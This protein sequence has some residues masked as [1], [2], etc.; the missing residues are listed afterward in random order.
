M[1]DRLAASASGA[2]SQQQETSN[3]KLDAHQVS[4]IPATGEGAHSPAEGAPKQGTLIGEVMASSSSKTATSSS[5][6]KELAVV[7]MDED[8]ALAAEMADLGIVLSRPGTAEK[9]ASYATELP[10]FAKESSRKLAMQIAERR[11]QLSDAK[12]SHA[13]VAERVRVMGAHLNNVFVELSHTR[14]LSQLKQQE[15]ETVQRRRRLSETA[16][17]NW[18]RVVEL[19]GCDT[20]KVQAR[21]VSVTKEALIAEERIKGLQ[22]ETKC[23]AEELEE[24]TA[25]W[26][27]KEEDIE[28]IAAFAKKDRSR[29]RGLQLDL[30]RATEEAE[31]ER[32]RL[33][34]V[35][36]E[37]QAAQLE[38]ENSSERLQSVIKTR[39]EA[40]ERWNEYEEELL[41][42]DRQVYEAVQHIERAR[43]DVGR[44]MSL[45][46]ELKAE[47]DKVQKKQREVEQLGA[48]FG[49]QLQR[50]QKKVAPTEEKLRRATNEYTLE[51]TELEALQAQVKKETLMVQQKEEDAIAIG[52]AAK[53]DELRVVEAEQHCEELRNASGDLE[54]QRAEAERI[55]CEQAERLVEL[56]AVAATLKEL[57]IQQKQRSFQLKK[58][59]E[60][61]L[62]ESRDAVSLHRALKQ[63]AEELDTRNVNQKRILYGIELKAQELEA[64]IARK[65]GQQ[66]Q[67]DREIMEVKI[68]ELTEELEIVTKQRDVVKKD[69]T[70]TAEY[71]NKVTAARID[72]EH[73]RAQ[74]NEQI[75][76][77][78]LEIESTRAEIDETSKRTRALRVRVE[79]RRLD[80]RRLSEKLA[81][82]AEKALTLDAQKR[83]MEVEMQ[84]KH[85]EALGRN[86]SETQ[87]LRAQ[88]QLRHEALMQ[89]R[90][91]EKALNVLQTR[92]ETLAARLRPSDEEEGEVRSQAYFIVK[93]AQQREE[94][95]QE[96]DALNAEIKRKES[97]LRAMD[98]TLGVLVNRNTKFRNA[99]KAAAF[100]AKV[101]QQVSGE[102]SIGTRVAAAGSGVEL[103]R[104]RLSAKQADLRTKLTATERE[105]KRSTD[106]VRSMR[107]QA[108]ELRQHRCNILEEELKTARENLDRVQSELHDERLHL[109]DAS[110]QLADLY[111]TMSGDTASL[112]EL[113]LRAQRQR[114]VLRS[115]RQ[116]VDTASKQRCQPLEV[117]KLLKVNK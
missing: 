24:W 80:V 1:S 14:E 44:A 112:C 49:R 67:E 64:A 3:L 37:T 71:L 27:E 101:G 22:N 17:K 113:E 111:N 23:S 20:E 66:S 63:R 46:A 106:R 52:E 99:I 79:E 104:K 15:L 9:D 7:D 93:A 90:E 28:A 109:H 74:L 36:V 56:N 11:R 98:N 51:V 76:E 114:A 78:R 13:Q 21:L 4:A 53:K 60:Q 8:E 25:V 91:Q 16:Y 38:L 102:G 97:E 96:G 108:R 47:L 57:S 70:R 85:K 62:S 33:E 19:L 6:G 83:S 45:N 94:L 48:H 117:L 72:S 81:A 10:E 35:V 31:K 32:N 105:L 75:I 86:E 54:A 41:S 55:R 26:K 39:T 84:E 34:H 65:L 82:V 115:F 95:R 92:Y 43:E 88:E 100:D 5:N 18:L 87:E 68:E 77:L 29:I 69:V 50:R 110:Q 59:E 30:E 61:L 103:E 58:Q 116:L 12:R 73:S 42:R 2:S 89:V 40:H 107:K